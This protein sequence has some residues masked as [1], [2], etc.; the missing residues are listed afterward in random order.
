MINQDITQTGPLSAITLRQINYQVNTPFLTKGDRKSWWK[1]N[2][3]ELRMYIDPDFDDDYDNDQFHSSKLE[4]AFRDDRFREAFSSLPNYSDL[5]DM[6]P[7]ER[8]A[9]YTKYGGDVNRYKRDSGLTEKEEAEQHL[10]RFVM[11]PEDISENY[12]EDMFDPQKQ[13]LNRYIDEKDTALVNSIDVN[14]EDTNPIKTKNQAIKL[15]ERLE[16]EALEL[17]PENQYVN[18]YAERLASESF[19]DKL[20]AAA[21]MGQPSGGLGA[22]NFLAGNE[23]IN[24]ENAAKRAKYIEDHLK[25]PINENAFYDISEE[26]FAR[27]LPWLSDNYRQHH[28][29]RYIPK[30]RENI[31]Q[32]YVENKKYLDAGLLYKAKA[33]IDH[34]YNGVIG[35]N[36]PTWSSNDPY[37]RSKANVLLAN[38]ASAFVENTLNTFAIPVGW[39]MGAAAAPFGADY[40]ATSLILP[41]FTH[42]LGKKISGDNAI[43][44]GNDWDD[45]FFN[46]GVTFGAMLS[47]TTLALVTG[48]LGNSLKGANMVSRAVKKYGDITN[49]LMAG[50]REGEM[51]AI[52]LRDEL[53]KHAQ[54]T[55]ATLP[56]YQREEFLKNA[57][58]EAN[59]AFHKTLIEEAAIVDIGTIAGLGFLGAINRPGAGARMATSWQKS[60]NPT[61]KLGEW[62]IGAAHFLEKAT[63]RNLGELLEEYGQGLSEG[64]NKARAM[65][66][67]ESYAMALRYGLGSQYITDAHKGLFEGMFDYMPQAWAE[68]DPENLT[69]QI[70]ISTLLFNGVH[71]PGNGKSRTR[72]NAENN[73]KLGKL[74]DNIHKYSPIHTGIGQMAAE[75]REEYFGQKNALAAGWD[76]LMHD[77]DVVSVLQSQSALTE[78]GMQMAEAINN[79]SVSDYQKASAAYYAAQAVMLANALNVKAKFGQQYVDILQNRAN[80]T[81]LNEE[82]QNEM[83]AAIEQEAP[84]Y[85]KGLSREDKIDAIASVAQQSLDLVEKAQEIYAKYRQEGLELTADIR[86]LVFGELLNSLTPQTIADNWQ[87]VAPALN[88]VL[89]SSDILTRG[90]EVHQKAAK[91]LADNYFSQ[92][93]FNERT[94]FLGEFLNG[95]VDGINA[96]TAHDIFN[97]FTIEIQKELSNI[98]DI[99]EADG[100][101]VKWQNDIYHH[102]ND[103]YAKV[104][105][106][107]GTLSEKQIA[108]LDAVDEKY[109][110]LGI[111]KKE[112]TYAQRLQNSRDN[113]RGQVFVLEDMMASESYSVEDIEKFINKFDPNNEAGQLR[114]ALQVLKTAQALKSAIQKITPDAQLVS[115]LSEIIDRVA[116]NVES[117]EELFDIGSYGGVVN[118]SIIAGIL[119]MAI[120][121]VQNAANINLPST[122]PIPHTEEELANSVSN[123]GDQNDDSP[124]P[125]EG[126]APTEVDPTDVSS[127]ELP[128]DIR[129]K[130]KIIRRKLRNSGSGFGKNNREAELGSL[131]DKVTVIMTD[132]EYSEINK[133]FALR[134]HGVINSVEFSQKTTEVANKIRNRV[135]QELNNGD[136][137]SFPQ[138]T[139]E[140]ESGAAQVQTQAQ[141][142]QNKISISKS[143]VNQ[144]VLD[145]AEGKLSTTEAIEKVREQQSVLTELEKVAPGDDLRTQIT[146]L[147]QDNRDLIESYQVIEESENKSAAESESS[148]EEYIVDFTKPR[149]RRP[150]FQNKYAKQLRQFKKD[151]LK[152]FNHKTPLF[153]SFD[154]FVDHFWNPSYPGFEAIKD[155]FMDA[156]TSDELHSDK[157][158]QYA[159][160]LF[161]DFFSAG[162]SF[163][164][165][166]QGFL[167]IDRRLLIRQLLGLEDYYG[168]ATKEQ[169]RADFNTE[170]DNTGDLPVDSKKER[171][172]LESRM[173]VARYI[174]GLNKD[175]KVILDNEGEFVDINRVAHINKR[176]GKIKYPPFKSKWTPVLLSEVVDYL[177]SRYYETDWRAYL[178]DAYSSVNMQTAEEIEEEA[179]QEYVQSM[180]D[181][182]DRFYQ[183][184]Y[185]ENLEVSLES[186]LDAYFDEL[187]MSDEEELSLLFEEL[188]KPVVINVRFGN[189]KRYFSYYTHN[190]NFSPGQKITINTPFGQSEATIVGYGSSLDETASR[191][192]LDEVIVP[193]PQQAQKKLEQRAQEIREAQNE[194]KEKR[195]TAIQNDLRKQSSE[196][197]LSESHEEVLETLKKDGAYEYVEKGNLHVGDEIGFIKGPWESP[198]GPRSV[199]YIVTK[200]TFEGASNGDPLFGGHQVIGLWDSDNVDPASETNE[201]NTIKQEYGNGQYFELS[202]PCKVTD[203]TS[204]GV[205]FAGASNESKAELLV[206]KNLN[207]ALDFQNGQYGIVYDGQLMPATIITNE[208]G[209]TRVSDPHY[210]ITRIF[211]PGAS[212]AENSVRMNDNTKTATLTPKV[213]FLVFPTP[214]G[215]TTQLYVA[216][217][218]ST[219]PSYLDYITNSLHGK[220]GELIKEMLQNKMV[221]VWRRNKPNHGEVKPTTFSLTSFFRLKDGRGVKVS[222]RGNKFS[223][224]LADNTLL[225]EL[226][227]D[228]TDAYSASSQEAATTLLTTP[229][230]GGKSIVDFAYEQLVSVL[231]NPVDPRIYAANINVS[232][233]Q[234]DPRILQAQIADGLLYVP[235]AILNESNKLEVTEATFTAY[236]EGTKPEKKINT[237]S[238]TIHPALATKTETPTLTEAVEKTSQSKPTTSK[239]SSKIDLGIDGLGKVTIGFAKKPTKPAA[240]PKTRSLFDTVD[241]A[242]DTDIKSNN[243]LATMSYQEASE[244]TQINM[245]EEEWNSLSPQDRLQHLNCKGI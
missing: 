94:S 217:V 242:S 216:A 230:E 132:E 243:S 97:E 171:S 144:I 64:V 220:V 29:T 65:D 228:Y 178:R 3:K 125:T 68:M 70:L 75:V 146:N 211:K 88:K 154:L 10:N 21:I 208:E 105:R 236:I 47:E 48:A 96:E 156:L 12:L 117:A 116:L 194:S 99:I 200:K 6:S 80:I 115:P 112:R 92:S 108:A 66:N 222:F 118:N 78:I 214:S 189:K 36:Q 206:K 51:D 13:M 131:L 100:N 191:V 109:K 26:Q 190:L 45:A 83:L 163:N 114:T 137:S 19:A 102:W 150:R 205:K 149:K 32:L 238:S 22:L 224:Q 226:P 215:D 37:M 42:E 33:N 95:K 73:T 157:A 148:N 107:E 233:Y 172:D 120:A 221:E 17:F 130:I 136:I 141:E 176:T 74:L 225:F 91:L 87:D 181:E 90:D 155:A 44:Y 183:D 237:K 177:E 57:Y 201:I 234:T 239:E 134:E 39:L 77:D 123:E 113:I 79:R 167:E 55:A 122:E 168:I 41:N 145:Y 244:Y 187:D 175:R 209:M 15:Y 219:I 56:E 139:S 193:T 140:E 129:L 188:S 210:D 67:I 204:T 161:V 93:N 11:A 69:K 27:M 121:E 1:E 232:A 213:K 40:T 81:S 16:K 169:W 60:L 72:I 82:E 23:A 240:A 9:F 184:L 185:D 180:M 179:Y 170:E 24:K 159:K 50:F 151:V 127:Q 223:F 147:L 7:A 103:A 63:K 49:S 212:A 54:E 25:V 61:S 182:Q 128:D 227:Y 101:L 34:Y 174:S 76:A 62:G 142:I 2:K 31:H 106:G 119:T 198:A 59:T 43:A 98:N 207:T 84:E 202:N 85:L 241:E 197:K 166:K 158:E 218:D 186:Q 104:Q 18:E 245:S 164:L 14:N 8:D 135:E 111:A 20:G 160:M 86:P 53:L 199:V 196:E 162:K 89:E 124:T 38:T 235:N 152:F 58:R 4:R 229:I 71:I 35:E 173:I 195:K 153:D 165:N 143:A 192:N 138:F 52:N 30:D 5:A 231:T 46:S 110:L 133:L 203:V 126:P 28:D